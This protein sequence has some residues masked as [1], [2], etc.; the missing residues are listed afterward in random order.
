MRAIH[1]HVALQW[2]MPPQRET[3]RS[4]IR[5]LYRRA[6]IVLVCFDLTD[7][8]SWRNVK[9]WLQEID[10]YSRANVTVLIVGCKADLTTERAV[11]SSTVLE[12]CS[13]LNWSYVETS[14]KSGMNVDEVMMQAIHD[15]SA[16][17]WAMDT[18]VH[19]DCLALVPG[20]AIGEAGR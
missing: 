19:Q 18:E 14:A 16:A 2:D 13:A 3:F 5:G 7:F 11:E 15:V 12:L 9:Q 6:H 8:E 4:T 17:S 10:R 20:Q 1:S